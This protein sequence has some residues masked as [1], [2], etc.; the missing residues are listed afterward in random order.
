MAGTAPYAVGWLALEQPGPWGRKALSESRLDPTLGARIEA[1]C[2]AVDVRP[3]L[4]RRPGRPED[5]D[6]RALL[7][8]HTVPG[9]TWLLVAEVPD[10]AV[11]AWD[12]LAK[13][14]AIGDETEVRRLLPG[15]APA[16]PHLLVCANGRRDVCCA[17]AG[18]PVAAEV[19]AR[20]P[21]RVWEATHLGG[22]RFAPTAAVLPSGMVH[23]RLSAA[24]ALEVL[25][26]ADR[27]EVVPASA[28]GRTT[29]HGPAQAADLAVRRLLDERAV[30]ALRVEA[31]EASDRWLVRHVD[32]RAWQVDVREHT[33][34][35]VRAESCGK[36][37]VPVCSWVAEDPRPLP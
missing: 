15:A 31:T 30:G 5:R 16:P 8:A 37:A 23:G 18:R 11:V 25:A 21:D 1:A 17:I 9:R 3:A 32:G 36:D 24:G 28:R 34:A 26:A 6:T 4:V 19:A 7:T 13:A 35:V 20:A 14:V 33:P 22:H 29:W 10:P 2:A 27:D 12:D